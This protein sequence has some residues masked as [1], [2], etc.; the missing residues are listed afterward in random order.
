EATGRIEAIDEQQ[1]FFDLGF[2]DEPNEQLYLREGDSFDNYDLV[3]GDVVNVRGARENDQL[4][5]D[6]IEI[7]DWAVFDDAGA[8]SGMD[9]AQDG[10]QADVP[11]ELTD[12][13][14]GLATTG[15]VWWGDQFELTGNI[16]T[17]SDEYITVTY[18][19]NGQE[20]TQDIY[21]FTA[22]VGTGTWGDY[23]LTE[24]DVVS[25]AGFVGASG[26][27]YATEVVRD[28]GLFEEQR[29]ASD[30]NQDDTDTAGNGDMAADDDLGIEWNDDEFS[31]TGSI[32]GQPDLLNN[33]L[34]V[35]ANGEQYTLNIADTVVYQDD[36]IAE[37]LM[38]G[39][40]VEI[41]GVRDDTGELW[42]HSVD[43]A[44]DGLLDN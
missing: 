21:L 32:V 44:D 24:D 10:E 15:I 43:L 28:V 30:T 33:V 8:Q 2:D 11:E 26:R 36:L 23:D 20:V 39:D 18:P 34:T 3:E 38:D 40:L 31:L 6:E 9:D 12:D 35:E 17:I 37:D 13:S 4:F 29:P 27:Y 25:M 5:A 1:G 42:A 16:D 22:P 14:L 41:G 19:E 7:G